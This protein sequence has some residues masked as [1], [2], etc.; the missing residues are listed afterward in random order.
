MS[1]I[2]QRGESEKGGNKKT[3]RQISYP[4]IRTRT[5]VYQGVRN[6]RFWKVWR[7]LFFCYLRFGI[8][9]FVLLPTIKFLFNIWKPRPLGHLYCLRFLY[10]TETWRHC[11]A[12][13]WQCC[14][15]IGDCH[16]SGWGE[17]NGCISWTPRQ[18]QAR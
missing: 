14:R 17:S 10:F 5:C 6:V 1:V 11:W 16:E 7:T 2:R 3:A 12:S 4:L 9:S 18:N 15:S 13:S 8:R